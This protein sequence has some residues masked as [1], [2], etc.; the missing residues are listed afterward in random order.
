MGSHE[1]EQLSERFWRGECT[2][3]EEERL[4]EAALY[5]QLPKGNEAL[6]DYFRFLE[7]E[8]SVGLDA[9]FDE[10]ILKAISPSD[11]SAQGA[12]FWRMAAGLA[13]L[14]GLSYFAYTSFQG[15]TGGGELV[16]TDEFVDTYDDPELAYKE[17]K[18]ALMMMST[19]INTGIEPTEKLGEFHRAAKTLEEKN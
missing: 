15:T 13:L 1:F 10:E 18:R 6:L 16:Q 8:G 19:N 14:I 7:K 5:G 3:A 2:E 12:Y 11:N 4:R 17:V 9:D